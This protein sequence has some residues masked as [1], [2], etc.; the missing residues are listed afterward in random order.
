[1]TGVPTP[2]EI[3][4]AGPDMVAAAGGR[5]F[6]ASVAVRLGDVT[7]SGRVRLDALARYL[8]DVANDDGTDAGIED[9][10]AW[11]VR[12]SAFRVDHWPRYGHRLELVTW[13]SGTGSRWAERRTTASVDGRVAVEAAALWVCVDAATLRPSRLTERF[14]QRYGESA[15][16]RAVSSR[17]VHPDPTGQEA[18]SGRPWPLR[19]ADLDLFDHVNNAATWA[20]VEDEVV[21]LAPAARLR[22]AELEYRRPIERDA[23]LMV[24]G[25][26]HGGVAR[27]WLLSDGLVLASALVGLS[28]RSEA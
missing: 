11:V 24:A 15:G 5:Q 16:P 19:L 26:V 14:W 4:A 28:A 6:R 1:M 7:P 27:V 13:A 17:L 22:W 18:A 10:L 20:A 3:P 12:R 2:A 8:Q 9:A 21:R 23:D 25:H